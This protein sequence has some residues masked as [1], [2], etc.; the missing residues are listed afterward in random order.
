MG[1][2]S[3]STTGVPTLTVPPDTNL[4]IPDGRVISCTSTS[5]G[6]GLMDRARHQSSPFARRTM[7]DIYRGISWNKSFFSSLFCYLLVNLLLVKFLKTFL[8]LT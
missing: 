4:P 5:T 8:D 6:A 3:P 2:L 7:S 1:Q